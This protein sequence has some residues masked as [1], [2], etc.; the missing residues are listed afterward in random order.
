MDKGGAMAVQARSRFDAF[1]KED[2]AHRRLYTDPEIFAEE[3]R[4]IFG[5]TWVFVGHESEIPNPGD[6]KTFDIA[7]QPIIVSRHTDGQVHVVFN[8]CMHRG[9]VV[10]EFQSG[11]TSHFRCPY[12]AW[13]YQTNGALALVP[14]RELFG[15]DFDVADYGLIPLPRVDSY[16]GFIFASLSPTGIS[17]DEHLGR[18][19]HYI[20]VF[21]HRSPLGKVQA[22]KPLKYEFR[23]NWKFQMENMSDNYHAVYV[24]ASALAATRTAAPAP[25]G[26]VNGFVQSIGPNEKDE[27]R[28]ERS[29]G[30]G[31]GMLDYQG[32]RFILSQPER[33]PTYFEA[34]AE[35][36]GEER[37][38]VLAETDIH[39][40][41]YPNLILHTNYNHYRVVRP[42]A[43]NHTEIN[44]YPC[45][46]VG[47]P[48]DLNTAL[49]N[50]SAVH[51]SPAGRIQVDDL[52]VFGRVQQGL[53]VE[54][55]E[56]VLFKMHGLDEHVN[57]D[58]ELECRFLSEMIPRGYYREWSRLMAEE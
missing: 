30:H 58:G 47:A 40:M 42:L 29:F 21:L 14:N 5:R 34:L 16:G 26:S 4:R 38:R 17:L 41:V 8:R 33:H 10:C 53:S 37:A 44:T 25:N 48:D 49:I 11:N 54:A 12:H 43:V 9:A 3:M 19:K 6:F 55:A 7:G 27:K 28:I 51:V 15:S 32:S 31:H 2:A 50:A 24:H 18:A 52:E 39:V 35:S 23:G 45:K 13:V 22:T 46:L 1:V 56:W 20:D 57:E 36:R